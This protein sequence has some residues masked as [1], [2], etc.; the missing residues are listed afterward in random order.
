MATQIESA[1]KGVTTAEIEAV[2]KDENVDSHWLRGQVAEGLAVICK[3]NR[4]EGSKPLAVGDRLRTKVNANIGTSQDSPDEDMELR[5]LAAAVVA[6]A[7]A[8]MDLST[9]GDLK[10]MRQKVLKHS[11]VA[12]GTVPIY[13]T[14]VELVNAGRK[15]TDM[16]P[17]Q[18]FD[19]IEEHGE[20]GVDFITVHCGVTRL[21]I[22][23]LEQDSRVLDVVSR[24]GAFL[25][26]WIIANGQDN[27]LYEQFDRLLE[28]ARRYDMVLSLGDG[29]RPGAIAD[30]SDRSQI[31]ELITLGELQA[32]AL[33]AGVQVMIEGP[34]HV[35]LHQVEANVQIEK[36][37]CHGAPFYVLG[38]I[39]TDVAPG[40][41]HITS[42]I[43]GAVAG[44]AGADFL[45]Y[46]TPAEH[47]RLPDIE[48]VRMGVISA[49][50]AAHAADIAKGIPGA[51]E[52]DEEMSR[53]RKKL[54]W[55][56]MLAC[57]IDSEKAIEIRLQML[58]HTDGV[59][60]MCGEFCSIRTISRAI[61]TKEENRKNSK[62]TTKTR[63]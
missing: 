15:I 29:F 38:P 37:L 46:V 45:C 51:A 42:A 58:S 1:R 26:E 35:P 7:D 57:G 28:I 59:C 8:V 21:A 24:G 22:E 63:N 56:G 6:G 43:G 3:N 48:D 50:I 54:D 32:E 11:P 27:P 4:R 39:V 33:R 20:Q 34:G 44:A 36:D 62:E 49:R 13:E 12:V 9:G 17:D 14:A 53:R 30:A 25:V 55:D 19:T 47:L 52:W 23:R 10:R 31:Q 18:L 5:K 16:S 2:A 61:E 40:Y 41:D 60:S